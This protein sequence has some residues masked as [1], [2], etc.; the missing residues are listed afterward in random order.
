MA[1][2]GDISVWVILIHNLDDS[3]ETPVDDTAYIYSHINP[4][5]YTALIALVDIATHDTIRPQ[6]SIYTTVNVNGYTYSTQTYPDT[7]VNHWNR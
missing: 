2:Y 4:H 7:S 3:D 1:V 6:D 5:K